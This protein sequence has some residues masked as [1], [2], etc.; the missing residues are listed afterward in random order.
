MAVFYGAENRKIVQQNQKQFLNS[1][2][3]SLISIC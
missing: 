3:K 2:N 1:S